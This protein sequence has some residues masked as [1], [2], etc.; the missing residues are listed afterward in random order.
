MLVSERNFEYDQ[1]PA[2]RAAILQTLLASLA[3]WRVTCQA[4]RRRLATMDPTG[5]DISERLASARPTVL[6]VAHVLRLQLRCVLCRLHALSYG[7]TY[8]PV[9]YEPAQHADAPGCDA[10]ASP[11]PGRRGYYAASLNWTGVYEPARPCRPSAALAAEYT[12]GYATRP[13]HG[14]TPKTES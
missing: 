7:L 6:F 2:A 1:D 9:A 12:A 14:S 3:A 13:I 5:L 4:G 8:A 10:N 11:A